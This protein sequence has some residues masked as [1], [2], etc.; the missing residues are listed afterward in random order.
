M[1]LTPDNSPWLANVDVPVE[2]VLSFFFLFIFLGSH[3]WHMEVPRPGVQVRVTAAGLYHS[4]INAGSEPHL[5]P[6]PQLTSTLD[7]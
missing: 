7:P 4:H 2:L 1:M 6:T 5:Q 3:P